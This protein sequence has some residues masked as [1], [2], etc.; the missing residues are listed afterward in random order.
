MW[1]EV[2]RLG[3]LLLP[4]PLATLQLHA[5]LELSLTSQSEDMCVYGKYRSILK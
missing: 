1:L 5:V 3:L 2:L 4:Q